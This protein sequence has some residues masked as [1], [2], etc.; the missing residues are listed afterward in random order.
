[1]TPSQPPKDHSSLRKASM[2]MVIPTLLLVAPLVGFFL[3]RFLDSR[4]GTEPWLSFVGLVL[5]FVAAGREIVSIV[6]K[7]RSEGEDGRR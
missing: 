7:V 1:M 3:G 4:F 2:L 5:G 6:R